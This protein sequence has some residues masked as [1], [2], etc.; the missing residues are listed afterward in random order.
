MAYDSA[1]SATHNPATGGTPTAAWGDI[2]NA[3]FAYLGQA[4]TSFTPTWTGSGG[5]PA[6]G[7]GTLAGAYL[8]IGKTLHLRIWMKAGT[9]TT[10][11]SGTWDFLL[12]NSLAVSSAYTQTL[13]V[14]AIDNGTANYSDAAYIGLG[15]ITTTLRV[16][17]TGGTGSYG[18]AVPFT[19]TTS[20][21]LAIEGTLEVA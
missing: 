2:L 6:I 14:F 9:T 11:G 10:F 20:D 8:Q 12:P 5:N 17:Q 21:E 7:N 3:N 13:H 18:S 1:P 16:A 4:W 15:G 19:W